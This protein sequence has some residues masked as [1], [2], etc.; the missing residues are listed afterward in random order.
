M[1]GKPGSVPRMMDADS[2]ERCGACEYKSY[3]RPDVYVV[4]F[5]DD[6]ETTV[7]HVSRTSPA[8]VVC[9]QGAS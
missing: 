1:E 9:L 8:F 7:C 4:R 6:T 2:R 5:R 3:G